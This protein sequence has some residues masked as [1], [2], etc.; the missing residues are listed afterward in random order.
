MGGGSKD[1]DRHLVGDVS[2]HHISVYNIW[3]INVKNT[4]IYIHIHIY[5]YV[6]RYTNENK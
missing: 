1:N 5:I 6:K 4:Y 3:D 2:S